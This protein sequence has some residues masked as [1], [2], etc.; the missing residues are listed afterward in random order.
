MAV[1]YCMSDNL[2]LYP[3]SLSVPLSLRFVCC[4]M[5]AIP[6]AAT[7]FVTIIR[8]QHHREVSPGVESSSLNTN[9]ILYGTVTPNG[10]PSEGN[11]NYT[12]QQLTEMD[13]SS[14]EE[15]SGKELKAIVHI[16]KKPI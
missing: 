1:M 10:A 3:S 11:N 14:S 12:V 2:H 16:F 5:V 13:H 7:L 4:V 9:P 15:E 8:W 6:L